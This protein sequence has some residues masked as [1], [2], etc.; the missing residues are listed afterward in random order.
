MLIGA[1]NHPDRDVLEEIQWMAA[2]GLE[3]LDLTLE[4][5]CAATWRVDPIAIRD[6]LQRNNMAVVGHTAYYLPIA[7]PF[8]SLRKAAV[9]ELRHCM[10]MFGAV[11][12]KWMNIHP[13]RY[14][15]MHP[16]SFYIKRDILSL[17]ELL[18]DAQEVGVG[19]M[20][21]NLPHD[22]NTAEQLGEI[23]DAVPEVGLHLDYGHANLEVDEMSA[24]SILERFGERLRHVH[25][26]DNKGGREDLHL[27]IGAG[28]IN[29]RH[30][31]HCLK[32]CGYNGTITLEVFT[33]DK[34]YLAYSRDVLRALWDEEI[35]EDRDCASAGAV[36]EEV[37][38][39]PL[40]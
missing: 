13:D 31:V 3:F 30:Q 5:P 34:H 18:D 8:E 27:P 10:K 6:E 33:R 32:E 37:P 1:M 11:G 24:P 19:L 25:M 28:N 12:A 36:D 17:R 4:P 39:A 38:C 40:A 14:A 35:A 21:E 9:D 22:F 15:P 23:L 20:I 2:M 26:H 7:S 29:Y 16:R